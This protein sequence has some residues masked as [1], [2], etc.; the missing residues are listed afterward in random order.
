MKVKETKEFNEVFI[1]MKEYFQHDNQYLFSDTIDTITNS[2]GKKFNSLYCLYVDVNEETPIRDVTLL[3]EEGKTEDLMDKVDGLLFFD[4]GVEYFVK[5]VDEDYRY[6]ASLSL[7]MHDMPVR[8]L[9]PLIQ[10]YLLDKIKIDDNSI[11][12]QN[13]LQEDVKK[14][15]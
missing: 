11:E 4:R 14:W 8:D 1:F 3:W 10:M 2:N 12:L 6:I 9:M 5:V 7:S 13:D 15:R